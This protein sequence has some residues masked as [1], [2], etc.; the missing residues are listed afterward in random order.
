MTLES[1]PMPPHHPSRRANARALSL[2]L[3]L[4]VYSAVP[5]RAEIPEKPA[6]YVRQNYSK[7]NYRIPMRDGV[8]LYTIVYSPKDTSAAYRML[9]RRTP[10]G[11]HPYDDDKFR[12]GLGPNAHF[13]MEQY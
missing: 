10:Y 11:I 4:V 6:Q 5:A 2:A 13:L 8:H 9:M 12:A 1:C 3:A 7:K